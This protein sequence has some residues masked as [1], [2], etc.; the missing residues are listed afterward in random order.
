MEVAL[1]EKNPNVIQT[2]T[3]PQSNLTANKKIPMAEVV[4]P[5]IAMC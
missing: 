1:K 3:I 2:K 5:V 4:K